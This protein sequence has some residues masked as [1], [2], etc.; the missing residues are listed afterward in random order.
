MTYSVLLI[1]TDG[2]VSDID[3]TVAT[4]EEIED[5]PLSVIIVGVGNED[6]SDMQFLEDNSK[7]TF[8]PFV[9]HEENLAEDT[10][11]KLPDQLVNYYIA[12][13]IQ[14]PSIVEPDDDE[15]NVL[16]YNEEEEIEL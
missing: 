1:I 12:K 13:G 10:L 14:P 11:E 9:G 3:A 7:V 15:I 4:L 6:F 16:D 8:V 2:A 5:A